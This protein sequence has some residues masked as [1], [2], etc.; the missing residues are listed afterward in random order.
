MNKKTSLNNEQAF[1]DFRTA[2]KMLWRSWKVWEETG[3]VD[4]GSAEARFVRLFLDFMYACEKIMVCLIYAG[5]ASP[6]LEQDDPPLGGS[7][8][9]LE[10]WVI[11]HLR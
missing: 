8:G 4:S 5:Q 6:E 10:R 3:L 11:R 7:E 9:G 1:E 2:H